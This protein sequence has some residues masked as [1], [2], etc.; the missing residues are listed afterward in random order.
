MGD[1]RVDFRVAHGVILARIQVRQPVQHPPP[2]RVR[3]PGRIRQK[4]N[5]I[6]DAAEL[7]TLM[8][9]RQEPGT[10]EPRVK[11]LVSFLPAR[12]HDNESGKILVLGAQTVTEPGAQAGPAR[13]LKPRLDIGD[14][15]IMVDG[16]G[17]DRLHN[18]QVINDRGRMRQQLAD[19][20]ASMAVLGELERRTR[21]RKRTLS[22][23]HRGDALTHPDRVRQLGLVQF[24]ES[25]FVIQQLHLRWAARHE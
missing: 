14:G 3:Y 4:Q 9:G 17:V 5:G 1:P 12:D 6:A 19:P 23:G 2:N 25:G 24:V 15:R 11:G 8:F 13:L 22:R 21:H 18:A 10:P 16:L 7:D 20:R